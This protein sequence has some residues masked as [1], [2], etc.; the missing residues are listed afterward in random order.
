MSA[1]PELFDPEVACVAICVSLCAASWIIGELS[2]NVSQIDKLWSMV[3]AFYGVT[4]AASAGFRHPRLNLMA[5]L[6]VLYSVRLTWNFARRGGFS[7]PAGMLCGVLPYPKFWAGE[8]DYRWE[9]L[10]SRPPLNNP[11]AWK[12]FHLAFICIFQSWL[13]WA[14]SAWPMAVA[15]R[16]GSGDDGGQLTLRDAVVAALWLGA[17]ALE[18]VADNQQFLFQEEKHR[19]L[20]LKKAGQGADLNLTADELRG[21]CSSGLFALCRHPNYMGEQAM[22][23]CIHLFSVAAASGLNASLLG[24]ASYLALFQ[25]SVRFSE[26]ITATKYP[27]YAEYQRALPCFLPY[28]FFLRRPFP[29]GINAEGTKSD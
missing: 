26:E 10:R 17:W 23:V 12:A 7:F 19:K 28:G 18:A 1:F 25:G 14:V 6:T 16:A 15:L 4:F 8:E 21:F 27:A 20:R 5:F 9:V 29:D 3:T 22:W 2:G 13:L 24:V 11:V